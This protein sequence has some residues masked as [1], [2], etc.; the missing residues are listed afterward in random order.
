MATWRR[1]AKVPPSTTF[2]RDSH[3]PFK[4]PVVTLYTE[5][6]DEEHF[7]IPNGSLGRRARIK[8]VHSSAFNPFLPLRPCR[9]ADL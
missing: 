3:T 9:R 1:A 8:G 7:Q 6:K 2:I 5:G 4:R